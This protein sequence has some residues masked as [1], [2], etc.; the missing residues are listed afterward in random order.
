[1]STLEPLAAETLTIKSVRIGREVV[2]SCL[3][4]LD[5]RQNERAKSRRGTGRVKYRI[6]SVVVR[7]DR[8]D[9]D[10]AF[11]VS[12]RN[13]STGGMSILHGQ[14][15]Y[16]GNA[17]RVDLATRNGEWITVKAT[18]AHCRLIRGMLHEVGLMFD[19]PI[20]L[21]T[22]AYVPAD[23]IKGDNQPADQSPARS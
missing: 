16:T 8:S 20:D 14:M 3:D 1:M 21:S 4:D 13:I 12:T 19:A 11:I 15:M 22:L 2:R 7:P 6:P 23:S 10:I 18:V 17:C 9:K 5:R